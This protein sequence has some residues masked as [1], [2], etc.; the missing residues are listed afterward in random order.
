MAHTRRRVRAIL[1]HTTIILTPEG[2]KRVFCSVEGGVE[3]M[4]PRRARVSLLA[5]VCEPASRE[6][7][8]MK[9]GQRSTTT[10]TTEVR[11]IKKKE[12]CLLARLVRVPP[13]SNRLLAPVL[14]LCCSPEMSEPL[15]TACSRHSCAKAPLGVPQ[16]TKPR[17]HSPL[18]T[19]NVTLFVYYKRDTR[20]MRSF[21]CFK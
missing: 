16:N 5:C 18:A 3:R 7:G 9:K 15:K 10:Q 14:K 4:W 11:E 19:L 17:L 1:P 6:C 21:A 2:C 8:H 12:N 20:N 13:F